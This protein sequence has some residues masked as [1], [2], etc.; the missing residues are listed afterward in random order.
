MRAARINVGAPVEPIVFVADAQPP[1]AAP[2]VLSKLGGVRATAELAAL[3]LVLIGS[4]PRVAVLEQTCPLGVPS[5]RCSVQLLLRWSAFKVHLDTLRTSVLCLHS[6]RH[7]RL[8][9]TIHV[10]EH[11]IRDRRGRRRGL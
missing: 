6:A 11:T 8:F 9:G 10:K 3:V 1:R 5:P 4:S 2:Y 7:P